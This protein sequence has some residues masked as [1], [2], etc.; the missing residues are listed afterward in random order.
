M[1]KLREY[2]TIGICSGYGDGDFAVSGSVGDLSLRDMNEL[3]Q[4]ACVAISVMERMWQ[5][6]Q[7]KKP[8]NQASQAKESPYD[9]PL[10]LAVN[11]VANKEDAR[12]SA[13]KEKTDGT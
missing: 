6:A 3:R 4:A 2:V 10:F 11:D 8:E 12:R 1:P 7:A 13:A 5:D 9:D